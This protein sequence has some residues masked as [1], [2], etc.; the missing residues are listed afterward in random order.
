MQ[1]FM[2]EDRE[3]LGEMEINLP[4]ARDNRS[5]DNSLSIGAGLEPAIILAESQRPYE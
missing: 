3:T 5:D 4:V 1:H 2:A